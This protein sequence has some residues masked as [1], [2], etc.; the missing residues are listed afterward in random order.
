MNA[1]SHVLGSTPQ[2]PW[3][4]QRWPWLLMLGPAAV[5]VAGA[6]TTYL[7]V[8]RDDALVVGDYYKQ[9]K[10]INQDLRRDRV[11]S[12]LHM[13]ARIGFDERSGR[14]EGTLTSFDRPYGS[15]F[16]VMLAHPTQ[17]GKDLT[18][19][20]RTDANG[21]FSVA[22]PAL[23]HTHWQVVIEGEHKDWRLARSW[24]YPKHRELDITADSP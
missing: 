5:V 9:G 11:A 14:L 20:A 6:V 3:Y 15:V 13:S 24:D 22:L 1:H 10:A 16:Q 7:A 23:E 8:T 4:A 21:R 18:L 17:P 2:P 19:L 12:G